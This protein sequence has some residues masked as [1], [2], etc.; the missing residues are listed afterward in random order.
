MYASILYSVC[1]GSIY[2]PFHGQSVFGVT[3]GGSWNSIKISALQY[4]YDEFVRVCDHES[5]SQVMMM[6]MMIGDDDD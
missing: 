6:M 5:L 3:P 4:E 2:G 1:I